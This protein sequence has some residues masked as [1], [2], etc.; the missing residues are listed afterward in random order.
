EKR[1][2]QPF[3]PDTGEKPE[4]VTSTPGN[5]MK[6]PFAFEQHGQCGRWV[7]SVFPHLATQVDRMAFLMAIA[8]RSNVHGPASYL[9]NTGFVLPGFPCMGAWLSYGLG[10][11]TDNLPTFVVLPDARGLPYNQKGNFTAGFLP[12]A[13]QGTILNAAGTPPI[14][15]LVPSPKTDFVTPDA[16]RDALQ[17]LGEVNRKHATERPGDTRLDARIESYEL[18]ARMQKH[19]PEALDLSK[20]TEATRKLYG[21]DDPVAADFGRRCL[22][23]RRLLERGVRFVQVWSGAGGPTNNWDNHADIPKELPAIARQVDQPAAALLRDL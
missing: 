9:M 15:D 22:L 11:L 1:H 23:A 6:S 5:L 7:S 14:P 18:A 19:A 21:I 16:D 4:G 17:L 13:H 2:G 8:S 20:E 12:V 3:K 10:R